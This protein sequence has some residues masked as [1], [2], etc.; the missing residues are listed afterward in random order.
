M[1]Y[2]SLALKQEISVQRVYTIHCYEYDGRFSFSGE[3]H[4]FWDFVYVDRGE[5]LVTSGDSSFHLPRGRAVLHAPDTFHA[6]QAAGGEPLT[7]IILSFDCSS[8]AL[9]SL[10]GQP[11]DVGGPERHLMS[12]VV[13]DAREAFESPLN[14]SYFKLRRHPGAPYGAEQMI[15]L[16]IEMLLLLLMRRRAEAA[17]A[18]GPAEAMHRLN[19][20]Q[21]LAQRAVELMKKNMRQPLAIE[22]LCRALGVSR[23]KLQ[24]VFREAF[25]ESVMEY[26]IALRVETSKALIRDGC[27][28]FT[29]IADQLGFSSIHYF[30]KQFKRLA[31]MTP[32]EYSQSVRSLSEKKSC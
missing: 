21:A 5:A 27:L 4:P 20:N 24:R 14:G 17:A 13:A 11:F 1:L 2:E 31:G 30:S 25:N 29:Q 32:T 22:S 26:Y 28:N 3:S 19:D 15:R 7:L 6:L 10:T 23:D 9:H 18:P 12:R 8:R 16:N